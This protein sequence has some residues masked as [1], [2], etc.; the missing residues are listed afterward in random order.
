M[1]D[2]RKDNSLSGLIS[3]PSSH[4]SG[5]NHQSYNTQTTTLLFRYCRQYL[6]YLIA[7]LAKQA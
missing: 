1:T 4:A 2:Y 5:S 3:R 7:F 6:P